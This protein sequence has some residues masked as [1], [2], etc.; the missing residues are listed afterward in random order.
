MLVVQTLGFNNT[1]TL[2]MSAPPYFIS[3]A[4]NFANNVVADHRRGA[5][6]YILWPLVMAITG[7]IIAREYL[8]IA[9]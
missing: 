8:D 5:S 4:L 2:L 9:T 1:N 7:Y 6:L 3:F